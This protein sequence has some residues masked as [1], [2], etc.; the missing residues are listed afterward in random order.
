MSESEP[1]G[2]GPL[3]TAEINFAVAQTVLT[4]AQL[5]EQF[6]DRAAHVFALA[7]IFNLGNLFAELE[8]QDQLALLI[9]FCIRSQAP[10]F[11]VKS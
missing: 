10:S 11:H 9:Q 4:R 1:S 8:Y 2:E 7:T 3:T 6:G 5:V